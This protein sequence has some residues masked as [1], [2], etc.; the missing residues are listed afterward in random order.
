M[1]R[2]MLMSYGACQGLSGNRGEMEEVTHKV[3]TDTALEENADGREKDGEAVNIAITQ[4]DTYSTWAGE[5]RGQRHEHSQDL[6][7]KQT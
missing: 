1:V 5:P 7:K 3:G 4:S 2:R 6:P